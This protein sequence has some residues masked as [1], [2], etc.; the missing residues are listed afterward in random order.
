MTSTPLPSAPPLPNP[1]PRTRAYQRVAIIHDWLNGMR[2]GERVLEEFSELWPLADIF[3]LFYEPH[4]V[5]TTINRHRI[6]PSVL[7]RIPFA[8]KFYRHLL[9]L[10][11]WAI[12]RMDLK[13]YD[14]VLSISHCAAKGVKAPAGAKHVCYCLTP[15]RYLYDQQGAYFGDLPDSR[16][17][18]NRSNPIR[19]LRGFLLGRLRKWDQRTATNVDHFIAISHYVAERIKRHYG[20]EAAV[21]YPPVDTDFFVPEPAEGSRATQEIEGSCAARANR[22]ICAPGNANLPPGSAILGSADLPI[23]E[24]ASSDPATSPLPPR[25]DFYITVSAAVPYKKLDLTIK[26]FNETQ[27]PLIV[28]GRGPDLPRLRRM[29]GPTITFMPWVGRSELR[30]LYQRARAFVFS[31]EEDFGLAPVEAQACGCPVIPYGKGG[32]SETIIDGK[33]GLLFPEQTPESLIVA[34]KSFNPT[35]YSPDDIRANAERFSTERFRREL[36]D[37]LSASAI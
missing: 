12:G 3:T 37:Y 28:V 36:L 17:L 9:P 4:R 8:R 10:F 6:F 33:T 23:C 32:A 14:L 25:E 26:A 34:L 5:T 20:R 29:A 24:S 35:R 1:A 11:P 15:A 31:A 21:I 13:G 16:N 18:P 7:Q 19:V 30:G 27:L 22:E 2:G